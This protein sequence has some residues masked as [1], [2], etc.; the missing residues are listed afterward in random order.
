MPCPRFC[1][2][3]PNVF[4]QSS[5]PLARYLAIKTSAISPGVRNPLPKSN[6]SV[7]WPVTYRFP[8]LPTR[9]SV[10]SPP[11]VLNTL[12]LGSTQPASPQT[13]VLVQATLQ[14]PHCSREVTSVSQ[15]SALEPLQ[16]ALPASHCPPPDP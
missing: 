1:A 7:K 12:A 9:K 10:T 14:A 4:T 6:G 8:V 13:C 5:S 2:L 11:K 16:S 15:P 3:V